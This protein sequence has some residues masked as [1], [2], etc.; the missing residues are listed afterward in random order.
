MVDD[1]RV[2]DLLPARPVI[3]V[4]H[5]GAMGAALGSALKPVAGAV[6]WAAVGRSDRTSKRAELADLVGVPDVAALVGRADVVISICPPRA[7]R[8][9]AEQVAVALADQPDRPLYVEANAVA[10]QAVRGIGELLG[11][12]R[13]V[14]AAVLGPPAWESGRSVL[15]LSGAA[16][17]AVRALFE[18]SPFRPRVLDGGLG[19]AS[20]LQV[21]FGLQ[22]TV[23][24]A[25][26][27]ALAA[28]AGGL[29][30]ADVLGAE[31]DHAGVD[32]AGRLREA[33]EAAGPHAWRRAC[34]LAEAAEAIT[35]AE[36]PDGFCHATA[37]VYRRLTECGSG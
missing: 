3:G 7:A 26:W 11:P 20:A 33:A 32:Y 19:A 31:L 13:V 8:E 9:V 16:A 35:T 2:G 18:G 34:E 14:D 12:D 5:P 36:L 21:C 17:G 6:V 22:R 4:L 23:G 30:V 15:W 37:E 10:P 25:S 27:L 29:G 28:T 1:A 24:P